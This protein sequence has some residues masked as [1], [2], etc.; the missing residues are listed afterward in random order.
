MEEFETFSATTTLEGRKKIEK[1]GK[2]NKES[3][4]AIYRKTCKKW[5]N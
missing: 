3:D 1:V 4:V 5:R 2:D